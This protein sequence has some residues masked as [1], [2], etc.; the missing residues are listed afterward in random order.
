MGFKTEVEWQE[1]GTTFFG[2]DK[3]S[4]L[5]LNTAGLSLS[6]PLSR[7]SLSL[8]LS[9]A[10]QC[11]YVLLFRLLKGGDGR[12]GCV[13]YRKKGLEGVASWVLKMLQRGLQGVANWFLKV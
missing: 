8:S 5:S 2:N 6:A 3:P 4:Q 9:L 1:S 7:S 12:L 11:S 13:W 10:E